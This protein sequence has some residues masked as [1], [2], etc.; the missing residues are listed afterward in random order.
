MNFKV[1]DRVRAVKEYDDNHHIIGKTGTIIKI[2]A[3]DDY[4]SIGVKF[5]EHVNGHDLKSH[6]D[7]Y[8]CKN[9]HGWWCSE[10]VLEHVHNNNSK[11]VITTDGK[12][13]TAK[14]YDGK[15]FVKSAEAKCSPD[16]EFDFEKGT[17]IAM[18]RLLEWD[19]VPADE[20]KPKFT[21]SNLKNGMFVLLEDTCWGVVV[22]NR[23]ILEDGRY[24]ELNDFN[25]D[26]TSIF[27]SCG[28]IA[29]VKADCF[30]RAKKYFKHAPDAVL[31][32]R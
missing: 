31:F 9:G 3:F 19:F 8:F 13:T 21:K 6:F 22:D 25:T 30:N 24:C 29:V 20:V 27:N 14:L 2:N 11:I 28:I 7:T 16:D 12:T 18:S 17:G 26:L 10:S 32:K 4:H 23:I 1:G 5:D 15:K